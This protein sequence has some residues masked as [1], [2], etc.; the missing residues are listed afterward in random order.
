M[1]R[2]LAK[3]PLKRFHDAA[4]MLQ[5][6]EQ[7]PQPRPRRRLPASQ[8]AAAAI[9][10]LRRV[11]GYAWIAAGLVLAGLLGLALRDT[12][13][14][15]GS[16]RFFR[17]GTDAGTGVQAQPAAAGTDVLE[18]LVDPA[19]PES[20]AGHLIGEA[21]RQIQARRLTTP[22]GDNAWDSLMAA[23]R[24]DPEHLELPAAGTDLVAALGR[25]G[26]QRLRAQDA[27]G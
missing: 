6:M 11:P 16:E 3:G 15:T 21:R 25:D 23:S 4:D 24:I 18:P 7:V 8:W 17:A 22:E 19:A 10:A 12:G 26:V 20:Q 14:G 2:A 27:D 9:G 5:A 13:T 1:D